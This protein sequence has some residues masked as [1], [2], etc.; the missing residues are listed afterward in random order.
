M[1][2]LLRGQENS[3]P[4]R[5]L[6]LLQFG[7]TVAMIDNFLHCSKHEAGFW[8]AKIPISQNH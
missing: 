6:W 4:S 1:G 3:P 7:H 8:T 2:T 5:A